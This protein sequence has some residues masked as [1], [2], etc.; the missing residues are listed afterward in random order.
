MDTQINLNKISKILILNLGGIGD[1]LLSQPA[2]K[3]LKKETG[4]Q[5]AMAVIPRAAELVKTWEFVDD[6]KIIPVSNKISMLKSLLEL[7]KA[8]YDI[9]INMRTIHSKISALKMKLVLKVIKPGIACGRNTDN[10][11]DYFDMSIKETV[12]GEKHE[13]EY[14]IEQIE[15]LGIKVEEKAIEWYWTG[16]EKSCS[17]SLYAVI[18]PGAG[19]YSRRWPLERYKEI[20]KYLIEKKEIKKII[21]S[22][23]IKEIGLGEELK[24][25]YKNS[26]E[27]MAGKTSVMD[28]ANIVK[29]SKVLITNDTGLLHIGASLNVP[30]IAI[31]GPGDFKRYD[32]R[33]ISEN[34]RI[35]YKGAECAP[36]EKN[37][38]NDTIC[39]NSITVEE[40]KKEIDESIN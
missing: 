9:A 29:K 11:A 23:S 37:K 1:I 26:V 19:F 32:P 40:V 31:M 33:Y 36:C 3:A 8:K 17:D 20:V 27:N 22:G 39:L 24:A 28:V 14:S 30:M 21:I 15:Q 16:N 12:P 38:C 7:S 25:E 10:M 13:M 18:N 35:L 34:A 6:T 4:I 2:I 5:I